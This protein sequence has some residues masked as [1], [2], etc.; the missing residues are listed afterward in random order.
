[1]TKWRHCVIFKNTTRLKYTSCYKFNLL[2]VKSQV[3]HQ[4]TGGPK[5]NSTFNTV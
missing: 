2:Y 5:F 1:M 4:Q 3:Y